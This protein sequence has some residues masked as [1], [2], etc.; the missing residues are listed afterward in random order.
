MSFFSPQKKIMCPYCLTEIN[1]RTEVDTCPSCKAIFD[2]LYIEK[3]TEA[4]P[5]F[6]QIIGWSQVGKTVFL[7]SLTLLLS[8]I[9]NYWH[10][11]YYNAAETEET[12]VYTRNVNELYYVAFRDGTLGKPYPGDAGCGRGII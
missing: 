4:P 11:N 8:K 3:Y 5:C 1:S 10:Q 12:L 2:P 6:A 7:Q 9:G